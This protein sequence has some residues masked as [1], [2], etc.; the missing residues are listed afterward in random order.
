M[1]S[2]YRFQLVQIIGL[3]VFVFFIIWAES[4]GGSEM[5]RYALS[6]HRATVYGTLTSVFGALF[7]FIITAISIMASMESSPAMRFL[8]GTSVYP[9]LWRY[10]TRAAK[11]LATTALICLVGLFV[12]SHDV[13][14]RRPLFEFVA[15]GF[16]LNAVFHVGR[17]LFALQGVIEAS[18]ASAGR[19]KPPLEGSSS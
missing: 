10:F 3:L 1:L 2:R 11:V 6:T 12:N 5:I 14:C 4:R 19:R 17:C 13:P 18:I 16:S 7:G 8:Q 9:E 15:L